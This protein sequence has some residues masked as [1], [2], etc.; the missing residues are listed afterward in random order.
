MNTEN[1]PTVIKVKTKC[2]CCNSSNNVRRD[3]D[4]PK[5]MRC[6]DACGCDF[7]TAKTI[8]LNPKEIN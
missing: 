2:P 6:C 7:L 1:K 8:V 4:Y 3:F 5:T